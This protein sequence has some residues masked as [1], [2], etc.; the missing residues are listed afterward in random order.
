M[1]KFVLVSLVLIVTSTAYAQF[2]SLNMRFV[3]NW[4]FGPSYAVAYDEARDIIFCGSGGGVY[5]FDNSENSPDKIR[6]RGMVESLFYDPSSQNLYIAAGEIG[7]EIWDVSNPSAPVKLGSCETP[8][9]AQDVYVSGSYAYVADKTALQVIDV[10]SPSNPREM[11]SYTAVLARGVHVSGSYAYLADINA[12]S[13]IDV[14]V[15]SNP[16]KAASCD[17]D[18]N[19]GDVYVSGS[20]AYV[21]TYSWDWGGGVQVV[22]ISNPLEPQALGV[23]T[24]SSVSRVHVSGSYAYL[25]TG[26]SEM[27]AGGL[28]IVD[29]S[30]PSNPQVVAGHETHGM[31]KDVYVS[32]SYAYVADEVGGLRVVD[33][34]NP[35]AP[36][37]VTHYATP[38]ATEDVFILGS[39]AYIA[40]GDLWV[41]DIS[42]LSHPK[43]V[44]LYLTPG[45][46]KGV[47]VEDGFAYI[48]DYDSGLR[49]IDVSDLSNLHEVGHWYDQYNPA[50][51]I[52]RSES[53]AYVL[54]NS[55]FRV[56]DISDPSNPSALG[57]GGGSSNLTY[58]IYPEEPYV[59]KADGY[60]GLQ[61]LD[62]STPPWP[63]KVGSFDQ[64]FDKGQDVSVSGPY[65]YLL[66]NYAGDGKL[67]VV[68][69]S[70]PSNPQ[71]AGYLDTP[72]GAEAIYI[73]EGYAYIADRGA[74]LRVL[75]ISSPETPQE[76][77]YYEAP[78]SAID[79]YAS[80]SYVYLCDGYVGLQ[81]YENLLVEEIEEDPVSDKS[82]ILVSASLNRLSY[83]VPGKAQLTLY[84]ADGRKVLQETIEGKGVWD[85]PAA[86]PQGVYFA[87]VENDSG[88]ARTKLVVLR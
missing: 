20:Y 56:M 67:W 62:I 57:Y 28:A 18:R 59:Y 82:P 88:S 53:Y 48:A 1:K 68:D 10:S 36:Y 30:N 11:G 46:A 50:R 33:V 84:S 74:G 52:E 61:I 51:D 69:V 49:V 87:R 83:E 5:I 77:G 65:A 23:C 8:G 29:V 75:D 60:D 66:D 21:G 38:A 39:H 80:G 81:I 22:D 63:E 12:L 58:G 7:L 3:G 15:P 37:E 42:N 2:D 43:Q 76:V 45:F 13:V 41:L 6:T 54:H 9:Y 34:S 79:V 64:E 32:D 40:A 16:Q 71:E 14:S 86:L 17:C 78:V 27:D 70:D 47:H 26:L 25:A 72:G 31:S 19:P 4:P 73:S 35:A 44:A 24:T 85:A 55:G